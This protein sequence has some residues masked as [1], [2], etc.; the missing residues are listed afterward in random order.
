MS[1]GQSTM[2]PWRQ[3]EWLLIGICKGRILG[4]SLQGKHLSGADFRWCDLFKGIHPSS[5]LF[6]HCPADGDVSHYPL[7]GRQLS[8]FGREDGHLFV[9]PFTAPTDPADFIEAIKDGLLRDNAVPSPYLLQTLVEDPR[10]LVRIE[11][12]IHANIKTDRTPVLHQTGPLTYEQR[13]LP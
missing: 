4:M 6:I 12:A 7:T 8:L 11:F 3:Y 2:L 13:Y 1:D 5:A 9:S 10:D